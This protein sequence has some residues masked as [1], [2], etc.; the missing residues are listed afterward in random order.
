MA[1]GNLELAK[2][3][4]ASLAGGENVLDQSLKI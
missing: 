2:R 3:G 1:T 4:F